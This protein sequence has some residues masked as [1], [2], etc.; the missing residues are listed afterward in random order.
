MISYIRKDE[1]DA[2]ELDGEWIILNS[3][4]YTITTLNNM[5]GFCWSLLNN[6][7]T[8]QDIVQ[9]IK[10]QFMLEKVESVEEDIEAFL[11][12]LIECG[13]IKHAS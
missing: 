6:A 2:V 5:G 4:N 13:L 1:I 12:D 10:H 7:C 8:V 9:S 3:F 11:E